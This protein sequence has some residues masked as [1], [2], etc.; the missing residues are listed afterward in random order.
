MRK[1]EREKIRESNKERKRG[2]RTKREEERDKGG[3]VSV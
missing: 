3:S 2:L 1:K